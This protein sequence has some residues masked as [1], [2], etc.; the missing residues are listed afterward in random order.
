M[1]AKKQPLSARNST[2]RDC[3]LAAFAAVLGS[4]APLV[5]QVSE[6]GSADTR[7]A[8][9][10]ALRVQMLPSGANGVASSAGCIAMGDGSVRMIGGWRSTVERPGVRL[11]AVWFE[12]SAG[13]SQPM[14]LPS[15][16]NGGLVN[17]V[18]VHGSDGDDL[19][20]AGG[21]A[22]DDAARSQPTVWLW[23][24]QGF[25]RRTLP[26]PQSRGG[27]GLS[28]AVGDVNGDGRIEII[29]AGYSNHAGGGTRATVWFSSASDDF[30][31]WYGYALPEPVF[32][33]FRGSSA[34][35]LKIE[36]ENVLISSY[37]ISGHAEM[38][39]GS[40]LPV[41]WSS[42]D[43][44]NWDALVL[45]ENGAARASVTDGL[46]NTLLVGEAV[47]SGTGKTMAASWLANAN[48]GSEASFL[49]LPSG[50]FDEGRANG[51]IA[52]LIGLLTAG[53]V[54]GPDGR[55][56]A[57]W[58][59]QDEI[60]LAINLNSLS[61]NRPLGTRLV[62]ANGLL[63]YV[64][65]SNVFAVVGDAVDARGRRMGYFAVANAEAV[66]ASQP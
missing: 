8:A 31:T 60:P 16:A 25:S 34:S 49:A 27:G 6:Q 13:I 2:L 28:V 22:F 23:G 15:G 41:V 50:R 37:Q 4:G 20:I 32:G 42:V 24:A 21:T 40:R 54:S 64:E 7:N 38:S 1:L 61:S 33:D 46:S 65:Q 36:L 9:P 12:N 35:Y 51:I 48:G 44:T 30:A 62:T 18:S 11:P 19:L 43:G 66:V 3:R 47:D 57:I 59:H 26:T 56:A 14:T 58:I 53:D 10:A 52:I 45:G 29:A 39:D 5:A 55:A 17:G 63:P